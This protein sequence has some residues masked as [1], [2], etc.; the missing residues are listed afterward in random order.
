MPPLSLSLLNASK[1]H[2]QLIDRYT[3]AHCSYCIRVF[4]V[5]AE[6]RASAE[7]AR[8]KALLSSKWTQQ[9]LQL[10]D[11]DSDDE[12]DEDDEESEEEA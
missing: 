10:L 2:T 3:L 7:D 9:L 5:W 6:E 8:V 12:D 4:A 11:E 1:L